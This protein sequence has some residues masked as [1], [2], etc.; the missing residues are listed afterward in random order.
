M[1]KTIRFGVLILL[2]NLFTACGGDNAH[3]GENGLITASSKNNS[4]ESLQKNVLIANAEKLNA[5]ANDLKETLPAFDTNLSSSDVEGLQ[6]DFLELITLWKQ[7]EASYVASDYDDAMRTMPINIDFFNKGK[8]L[9]VATNIDAALILT[10]SLQTSQLKN[11]S[12]TV[13]GLEYMIFG[14]QASLSDLVTLMNQDSRKRIDAMIFAMDK[15]AI[16]TLLIDEFYKNDIKFIANQTD[17]FNI[18]VNTLVQSSFDLRE[19]RIGEAAGFIVKTKDDPNP[20][21]LEYYRSKKSLLAIEAILLVHQQIMGEQDFENF[22]S[23]ASTNG[24]D[25]VITKIRSNL[26]NA[27]AIVAEFSTPIQDSITLSAVDNK[28]KRLYD[29]ITDLQKNYFES[30][31]N[32]LNLTADIIEADGD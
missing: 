2:L 8:N 30:L 7:V 3:D 9:D 15:I 14:N 28:V 10:G 31:I 32:A 16:N 6:S 20:E 22:G 5:K 27:L 18:L 26:K 1:N 11:S 29:E 25:V 4:L 17:T 21:R 23:F 12:K 24:A 13:T 19:L